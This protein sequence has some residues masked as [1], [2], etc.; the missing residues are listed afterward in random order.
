MFTQDAIRSGASLYESPRVAASDW[1]LDAI[2]S[3]LPVMLTAVA[4]AASTVALW[5]YVQALHNY[6]TPDIFDYSQV[7]KPPLYYAAHGLEILC[8][9]G[10][11]L[12]ALSRTPNHLLR[13][14]GVG[15]LLFLLAGALM[16]VRGY[17]L[18]TAA[19]TQIVGST[20]PFTVIISLLIFVGAQPGNWRRA[21]RRSARQRYR[22]RSG[23]RTGLHPLCD[24]AP[25][26]VPPASHQNQLLRW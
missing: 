7:L 21:H 14:Y 23:E 20:G 2:L 13:R 19:S 8:V 25:S 22:Q 9:C 1:S 15:F 17:S 4:T 16:T 24:R 10:A 12:M 18:S 5:V 3:R 6:V 11:G 26:P